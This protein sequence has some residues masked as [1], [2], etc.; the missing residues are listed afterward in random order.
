M[1]FRSFKGRFSPLDLQDHC[2]D[3]I[4]ITSS[5]YLQIVYFC[6][7]SQYC[8]SINIGII[9]KPKTAS[10]HLTCIVESIPGTCIVELI[11]MDFGIDSKN[12]HPF[13]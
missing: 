3:Q 1:S 2:F 4:I 13:E 5:R 8:N 12:S 7:F 10:S 6:W 11:L 9:P